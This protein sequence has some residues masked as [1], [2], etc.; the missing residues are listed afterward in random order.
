MVIALYIVGYECFD[1]G[2]ICF[3]LQPAG[4]INTR[5]SHTVFASRSTATTFPW[6][7]IILSVSTGGRSEGIIAGLERDSIARADSQFKIV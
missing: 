2:R 7:A 1:A 6:H 4:Q 5:K 3:R